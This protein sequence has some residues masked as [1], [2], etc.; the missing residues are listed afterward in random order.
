MKLFREKSLEVVCS[1]IR[2][3]IRIYLYNMPRPLHL[4]GE[5]LLS[6]LKFCHHESS[7][8]MTV[9][10]FPINPPHL[11]LYTYRPDRQYEQ[12]ILS[13]SLLRRECFY[14]SNTL[15]SCKNQHPEGGIAREVL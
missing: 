11:R 14:S 8:F 9:A 15:H 7:S 12:V 2:V 5:P 3:P 10:H 6:C 4:Q 13:Y 1:Q